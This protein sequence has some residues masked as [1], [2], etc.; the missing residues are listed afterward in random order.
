MSVTERGIVLSLIV[1]PGLCSGPGGLEAQASDLEPLV[2]AWMPGGLD[3]APVRQAI[4]VVELPLDRFGESEGVEASAELLEGL[5]GRVI[6]VLGGEEAVQRGLGEV[7][8][9][10]ESRA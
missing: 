1:L 5:E 7:V 8:D 4:D 10:A 9:P 2:R 3:G 6:G